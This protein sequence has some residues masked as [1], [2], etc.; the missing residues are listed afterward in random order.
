MEL[1]ASYP[2]HEWQKRK[3]AGD[4]LAIIEAFLPY[5]DRLSDDEVRSYF[6]GQW[7][8]SVQL[9]AAVNQWRPKAED[10]VKPRVRAAGR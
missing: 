10:E 7:G 4:Q 2:S 3:I 1:R 5:L 9:A 6:V 8:F